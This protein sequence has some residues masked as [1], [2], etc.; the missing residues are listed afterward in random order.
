MK[1]HWL[2]VFCSVFCGAA[3]SAAMPQ[4]DE[5]EVS[6]SQDQA[7]RLLT[8]SYVLRG[9]PAVVTVDFLTNATGTAQGPWCSIG[10]G[11]FTNVQGTVNRAVSELG[12]T[13]TITWRPDESW[14]KRTIAA[15]Y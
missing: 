12:V 11:N 8:V 1:R 3:L 2:A 15:S 13:N 6:I 14:P 7:T 9:A 5:S 4:V 10:E